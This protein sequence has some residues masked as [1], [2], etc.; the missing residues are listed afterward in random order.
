[1]ALYKN[2][3]V[4]KSRVPGETVSGFWVFLDAIKHV[5]LVFGPFCHFVA[6]FGTILTKWDHYL[7]GE[8]HRVKI[9]CEDQKNFVTYALPFCPFFSIVPWY[10][11][12][13][14]QNLLRTVFTIFNPVFQFVERQIDWHWAWNLPACRLQQ[15]L[16]CSTSKCSGSGQ[17]TTWGHFGGIRS[18]M[19]SGFLNISNWTIG[20]CLPFS[21]LWQTT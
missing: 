10:S 3:S 13:L 9:F 21:C 18:L 17:R 7:S 12:N 20:L 4:Y 6:V 2:R 5:Y 1:M 15:M 14:F 11:H 8:M 19:V 16:E